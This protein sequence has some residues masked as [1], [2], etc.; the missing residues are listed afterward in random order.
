MTHVAS[1]S[2]GLSRHG[3]TCSSSS[4]CSP[5]W[6]CTPQKATPAITRRHPIGIRSHTQSASVPKHRRRTCCSIRA[7]SSTAGNQPQTTTSNKSATTSSSSNHSL[8][9]TAASS[10][11]SSSGSSSSDTLNILRSP[12]ALREA[13]LRLGDTPRSRFDEPSDTVTSDQSHSTDGVQSSSNHAMD[14]AQRDYSQQT[15]DELELGVLLE[16]LG[17][18]GETRMMSRYQTT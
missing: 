18:G 6:T 16:V 3:Q 8:S 2:G 15:A 9:S 10:S 1:S 13:L 12:A 4:S 7:W 17:G 11:N 5:G 14:G